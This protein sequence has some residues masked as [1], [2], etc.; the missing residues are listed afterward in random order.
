MPYPKGILLISLVPW[1]SAWKLYWGKVVGLCGD[2]CSGFHLFLSVYR[3]WS[4][5]Y[6]LS[7]SASISSP[8]L[9]HTDKWHLNSS[10]RLLSY[11]SVPIFSKTSL[12]N[13]PY[14]LT[15][16]PPSHSVLRADLNHITSL[17]WFLSR[18]HVIFTMPNSITM[19]QGSPCSASQ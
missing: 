7:C 12:E 13:F 11:I 9:G 10:L 14:F 8:T 15:L 16:I 2:S 1:C 19:F 6:P 17:K 3:L 4:C 18:L 5:K